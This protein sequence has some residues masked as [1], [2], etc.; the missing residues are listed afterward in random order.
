M[1]SKVTQKK[2]RE[3]DH[4]NLGAKLLALLFFGALI[5]FSFVVFGQKKDNPKKAPRPRAEILGE[6][7]KSPV[8]DLANLGQQAETTVVEAAQDVQK[9]TGQVLGT[10]TGSAANFVVENAGESLFTQIEKLPAQQ[11]EEIKQKICK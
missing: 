1:P 5:T 6:E 8:Q 3:E 10:V 2:K 7:T 4:D 11:Q 9:T